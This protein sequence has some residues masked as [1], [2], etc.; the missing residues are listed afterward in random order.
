MVANTYNGNQCNN[1]KNNGSSGGAQTH[2]S[3]SVNTLLET[4]TNCKVNSS[5][6]QSFLKCF[7]NM[8]HRWTI[9]LMNSL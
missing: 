3:L 9:N 4:L 1:S 7:Y 8:Q 5:S 6:R 2:G